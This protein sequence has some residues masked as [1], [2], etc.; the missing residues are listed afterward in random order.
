MSNCQLET[1]FK[2]V[3]FILKNYLE[4]LDVVDLETKRRAYILCISLFLH[5]R[6]FSSTHNFTFVNQYLTQQLKSLF[7]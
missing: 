1:S 2:R 6:R 4:W 7:Q 3:F 5:F